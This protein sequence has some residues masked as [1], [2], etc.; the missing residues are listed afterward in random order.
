MKTVLIMP[1][2]A[3]ALIVAAC[4]DGDDPATVDTRASVRFFNATTGMTGSGGFTTN[5]QFA[6]GS[7]LAS[8]QSTQTC[9]RVD[10][11]STSFGFGAANTGGTALSGSALATL[12]GQSI[13]DG[14]N[15]T[16]VATGAA[17]SP[18]LFMLDNNFSGTLASNQ[19]AVRFVNLA[20]GT[21]TTPNNF[22][23]F[24]GTFGAG[25]TLH[26]NNPEV[27]APTTFTT[28]PSGSNA[29]SVLWN[30]EVPAAITGTPGTLNLQAGTVNT[31]A[32]VPNTSGGFR[33]VNLPRC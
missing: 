6:T 16:V 24:L 5:G 13:T 19:A 9:S 31:I 32:I 10:A 2:L 12:N 18:T 11:G 17:P 3:A 25:G 26:A 27:G 22:A 8:G 1:V 28:V 30:H 15:Y 21:A 4:G 33:L 23:V 14:G 7:A 29:F 20:P